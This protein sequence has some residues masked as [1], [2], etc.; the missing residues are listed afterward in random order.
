MN[1]SSLA[2]VYHVEAEEENNVEE[3]VKKAV[4]SSTGASGTS[5]DHVVVE[6]KR[7]DVNEISLN[8]LFKGSKSKKKRK[9]LSLRRRSVRIVKD[10]R[11]NVSPAKAIVK[12]T[13]MKKNSS[14]ASLG[15]SAAASSS[16]S[17]TLV[18]SGRGNPQMESQRKS[19][20]NVQ[21]SSCS[22][23]SRKRSSSASSVSSRSLRRKRRGNTND[24]VLE[25]VQ[26][27]VKFPTS[28]KKRS[29]TSQTQNTSRKKVRRSHSP[30]KNKKKKALSQKDLE[31][32]ELNKNPDAHRQSF[33]NC[34]KEICQTE[35]MKLTPKK[36]P[37]L[38]QYFTTLRYSKYV[39][40][41]KLCEKVDNMD[42]SSGAYYSAKEKLN[43]HMGNIKW[44]HFQL[45]G[46]KLMRLTIDAIN[47]GGG[48]M[49]DMDFDSMVEADW[50]EV[51][52]IDDGNLFDRIKKHHWHSNPKKHVRSN[53]LHKCVSKEFGLNFTNAI[54]LEFIRNC[55]V[56]KKLNEYKK[57]KQP[58]TC[59]VSTVS[60]G[61][62]GSVGITPVVD[63]V[64]DVV[65]TLIDIRDLMT[66]VNFR[67]IALDH[68]YI[69]VCLFLR[70]RYFEVALLVSNKASEI[71]SRFVFWFN[72]IGFPSSIRYYPDKDFPV[73]IV[74]NQYV[75]DIDEVSYNEVFVNDQFSI[76]TT[77]SVLQ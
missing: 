17:R 63:N 43:A 10:S 15:K 21:S 64:G 2:S 71:R 67:N 12:K 30:M 22:S 28:S 57:L 37:R 54:C 58:T 55:K 49:N 19:K 29:A 5:V 75:Y 46:K 48:N 59:T 20:R 72:T 60:A 33:D 27:T 23:H 26:K 70:N 25:K 53:Q 40:Y 13:K 35:N 24:E 65:F 62:S 52:C 32:N 66:S 18:S 31:L 50:E 77:N 44:K 41:L 11:K 6:K 76:N 47:R 73:D 16:S 68:P 1:G 39:E 3:N 69:L 45:K 7:E 14:T 8:D 38:S 74:A 51:V 36:C 42:P 61:S 56:C 4:E 9:S 34:I